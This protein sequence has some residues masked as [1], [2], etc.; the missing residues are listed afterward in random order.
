MM[1][2]L[3]CTVIEKLT[4]SVVLLRIIL[5]INFCC[6]IAWSS[7][8]YEVIEVTEQASSPAIVTSTSTVGDR[9][10]LCSSILNSGTYFHWFSHTECKIIPVMTRNQTSAHQLNR[11]QLS[12]LIGETS[13]RDQKRLLAINA[14]MK[15]TSRNKW[16]I[17]SVFDSHWIRSS[18]NCNKQWF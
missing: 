8:G 4:S 14:R 12:I 6:C 13:L 16:Q 5:F 2:H 3:V 1:A 17:L 11:H 18:G 7:M 10:Q 15:K 9:V